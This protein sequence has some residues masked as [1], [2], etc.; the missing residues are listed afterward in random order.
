MNNIS[1]VLQNK[2]QFN[3]SIYLHGGLLLPRSSTGTLLHDLRPETG[4]TFSPF[5][6]FNFFMT[7]TSNPFLNSSLGTCGK[8]EGNCPLEQIYEQSNREY[9]QNT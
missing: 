4:Y 8:I 6:D 3:S 7:I 1:Y 5:G 9:L 2:I